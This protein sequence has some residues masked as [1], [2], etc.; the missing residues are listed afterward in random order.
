MLEKM[1]SWRHTAR[2]WRF[3]VKIFAAGTLITHLFHPSLFVRDFMSPQVHVID[4]EEHCIRE[5][6]LSMFV[7]VYFGSLTIEL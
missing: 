3:A 4:Y 1:S 5:S 7:S 6:S 2:R